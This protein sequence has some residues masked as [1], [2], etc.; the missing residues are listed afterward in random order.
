MALVESGLGHSF[1]VPLSADFGSG[2]GRVELLNWEFTSLLLLPLNLGQASGRWQRG[3][4]LE[5]NIASLCLSE[6]SFF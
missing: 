4:S 2:P 6:G 5:G 1:S 3:A